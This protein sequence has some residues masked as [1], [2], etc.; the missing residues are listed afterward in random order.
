MRLFDAKIRW[1]VEYLRIKL[2]NRNGCMADHSGFKK[3][4]T[5]Q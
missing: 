3:T 2:I 5:D 1:L 4:G